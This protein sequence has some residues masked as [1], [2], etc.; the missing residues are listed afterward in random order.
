VQQVPKALP[1]TVEGATCEAACLMCMQVNRPS[2]FPSCEC[3]ATCKTGGAGDEKC[4]RSDLSW[5]NEDPTA[6]REHWLGQCQVGR[7][8]CSDCLTEDLVAEN[9]R[10]GGDIVCMQRLRQR[11]SKPVENARYCWSQEFRLSSCEHFSHEPTENGWTCYTTLDDCTRG[12]GGPRRMK[13][14]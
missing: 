13:R 10:C 5:T 3:F 8:K 14:P 6:P 2:L 12:M 7:V 9:E 4:E 11:I 1:R